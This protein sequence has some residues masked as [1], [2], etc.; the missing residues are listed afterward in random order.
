M[1]RVAGSRIA[2]RYTHVWFVVSSKF[3]Q[4]QNMGTIQTPTGLKIAGGANLCSMVLGERCWWCVFA[5]VPKQPW[6]FASCSI[7]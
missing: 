1:K 5:I 4:H 3:S 6:H 2:G 7:G